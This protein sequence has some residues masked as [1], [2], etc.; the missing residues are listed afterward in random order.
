MQGGGAYDQF[1]AWRGTTLAGL[2][3]LLPAM[4][5]SFLWNANFTSAAGT[6]LSQFLACDYG[7]AG[8]LFANVAANAA[9]L[10]MTRGCAHLPRQ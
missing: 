2:S 4:N 5:C 10:N 1:A 9:A 7:S 8:S 6:Y 3:P